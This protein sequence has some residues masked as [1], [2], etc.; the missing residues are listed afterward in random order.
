MRQPYPEATPDITPDEGDLK[1]GRAPDDEADVAALYQEL[2][3][4]LTD[5]RAIRVDDPPPLYVGAT[6]CMRLDAAIDAV[7]RRSARRCWHA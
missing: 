6:I 2:W 3:D 1:S 7:A 5:W 4:A